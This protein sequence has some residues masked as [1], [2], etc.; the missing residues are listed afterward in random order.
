MEVDKRGFVLS[1][2][3]VITGAVCLVNGIYTLVQA[4]N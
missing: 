2:A 3:L 1:V 4:L